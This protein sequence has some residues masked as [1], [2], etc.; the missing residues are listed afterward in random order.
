MLNSLSINTDFPVSSSTET[1]TSST[2]KSTL[3]L[4]VLFVVV[5]GTLV[6]HLLEMINF[7]I[8]W[9]SLSHAL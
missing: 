2:G 6:I 1:V 4:F 9:L 7:A 5:P 3:F 8:I